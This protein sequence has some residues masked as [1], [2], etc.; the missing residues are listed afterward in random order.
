MEYSRTERLQEFL[1]RLEQAPAAD[2]AE[3]AFQQIES[4]L[5]A[6]E[7]EMTEI[8]FDPDSWMTDGRMYAPRRDNERDV[9]NQTNV[10]RYRSRSH[11]TFIGTN[12]SIEIQEIG[13]GRRTKVVFSKPGADGKYTS[14][15]D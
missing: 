6:V 1:N 10:K 14:E 8:P 5:N 2:S 12:G 9:P 4:I 3:A 15:L 11:N 13:G 7:D